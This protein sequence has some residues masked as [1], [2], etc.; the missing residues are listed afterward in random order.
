MP[1]DPLPTLTA[2]SD[3]PTILD[4]E[5]RPA[6][7]CW[8][9]TLPPP[10]AGVVSPDGMFTWFAVLEPKRRAGVVWPNGAWEVYLPT[11]D[12]CGG[13][14]VECGNCANQR[15]GRNVARCALQRLC[16]R[17]RDHAERN[18]DSKSGG[19]L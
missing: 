15:S 1:P 17:L 3:E 18:T 14:P 4:T 8:W 7:V 19:P 12:P 11:A 9:Q 10:T 5:G 6:L 16:R 2:W 13:R